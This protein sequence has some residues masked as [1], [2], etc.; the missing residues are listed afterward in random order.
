MATGVALGTGVAVGSGVALGT[1]MAVDTI[2]LDGAGVRRPR[3]LGVG[4]TTTN[5]NGGSGASGSGVA[6]WPLQQSLSFCFELAEL[7]GVAETAIVGTGTACNTYGSVL[8]TGIK[9]L[10][11]LNGIW[12]HP[13]SVWFIGKMCVPPSNRPNTRLGET[14]G[15]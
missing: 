1:G 6:T 14:R 13:V 4:V 9:P 7:V 2:V 15:E 5:T 10:P 3:S 11:P 12:Y 8:E